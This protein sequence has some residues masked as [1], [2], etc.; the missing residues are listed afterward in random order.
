MH[1]LGRL[2]KPQCS[3]TIMFIISAPRN[4]FCSQFT[5][6]ARHKQDC[7]LRTLQT[8]HAGKYVLYKDNCTNSKRRIL[9]YLTVDA[10][11]ALAYMMRWRI[12]RNKPYFI[13]N[14]QSGCIAIFLILSLK[15]LKVIQH[16][17]EYLHGNP[18]PYYGWSCPCQICRQIE[19]FLYTVHK[20]YHRP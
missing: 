4:Y 8:F 3:Q 19:N 12:A 17:L 18:W 9:C 10:K 15:W 2:A 1:F 20:V 13:E 14:F 11:R 5:S 16:I 7:F 6:E